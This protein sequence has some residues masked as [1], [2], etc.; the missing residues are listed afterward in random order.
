MGKTEVASGSTT[1]GAKSA[2]SPSFTIT[3]K[4]RLIGSG[5]GFDDPQHGESRRDALKAA[6]D[7]FALM[8]KN[9]GSADIEIS[10]S[11]LTNN[12]QFA[13]S[14]PIYQVGPGFKQ[15][16]VMRHIFTGIDPDA[17]NPD[18]TIQFSFHPNYNYSYDFSGDPS[19]GQYD[20][21][22]ICLHEIC[23]LLGFTSNIGSGGV[24]VVSSVPTLFTTYDELLRTADGNPL[25]VNNVVNPLSNL[26]SNS[27]VFE[28]G[29]GNA[30]PVYG[31]STFGGSSLSHFDNT[32]SSGET[33]LMNPGLSRG[34]TKRFLSHEEALVFQQLGYTIDLGV[35]TSVSD[36]FSNQYTE[37]A[38]VGEL[39][40]NPSS[41]DKPV[42]IN[43]SN[44]KER[45]ILVIVYDILGRQ[46]YSKVLMNDGGEGGTY[47]AIDPSHNLAAGMYI[48]VGSTKDELFNK[49]LIIR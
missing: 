13:I 20:F 8:I 2:D 28:L 29:N 17:S 40:P 32:R 27:V 10:E 46:A 21:Y 19:G 22:T 1:G 3:Y 34:Q 26:T 33:F 30:A 42:K 35:A 7:Y 12:L 15:N 37:A 24:S 49:K 11:S 9:T 16:N 31:P 39:Y 45:E 36:E 5:K 4:D 38:V 41:K 47:T 43:M 48:V 23:H 14:S 25:I 18:G 6:F 44:V